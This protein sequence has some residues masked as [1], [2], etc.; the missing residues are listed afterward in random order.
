MA[1]DI[2]DEEGENDAATLSAVGSNAYSRVN[3]VAVRCVPLQ[4]RYHAANAVVPPPLRRRSRRSCSRRMRC[5]ELRWDGPNGPALPTSRP[6]VRFHQITGLPSFQSY[7][8]WSPDGDAIQILDV[9]A[10]SEKVLPMY[11][12][13]RRCLACLRDK[14]RMGHLTPTLSHS[15]HNNFQ[16]FVRCVAPVGALL[17][18]LLHALPHSTPTPSPSSLAAN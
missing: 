7:I 17:P 3:K 6:A 11:F 5:G 18:Y 1:E 12:K 2:Y 8:R 9:P 4:Y 14:K 15:Q 13:V 10:F 16:S